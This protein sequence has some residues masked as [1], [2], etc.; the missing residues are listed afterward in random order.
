MKAVAAK[1][2]RHCTTCNTFAGQTA[3]FR[4]LIAYAQADPVVGYCQGMGFIVAVLLSYLAEEDAFLALHV[5]MWEEPARLRDIFSPGMPRVP[6]LHH[7]LQGLIDLRMPALAK[8]LVELGVHPSMWATQWLLTLFSYS[9]PFPVGAC[10][11][12]TISRMKCLYKMPLRRTADNA[13]VRVWDAFFLGEY[14][15]RFDYKHAS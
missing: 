5:L 9:F 10:A 13:V 4:V 3:L 7:V 2:Y 11:S 8:H 1:I 12:C 6:I 15:C 14:L